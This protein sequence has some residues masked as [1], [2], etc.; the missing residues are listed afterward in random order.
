M[1]NPA[2]TASGRAERAWPR[3]GIGRIGAGHGRQRREGVVDG[4]REHRYAIERAAGRHEAGGG[5]Q[6]EA[7]LEAD[8]VAQSGRHAAR[9]GSIGAERERN[10]AGADRDRRTRARSA[11][12][13]RGIEQVA[14][15]AVGRAHADQAGG[16]LIEIGLA[17]DDGAGPPEPRDAGR[18]LARVVREGRA[19]GG[20]RQS[21]DVDIVLDRD[22]H[23]VE[24]EIGIALGRQRRG[25]GERVGFIAQR[26]ENG[27][28]AV[29]ADARVGARDRRF[30]AARARTMR[31][32]DRGY[33]LAHL[34]HP[35]PTAI[36]T[37]S[38]AAT[39]T[40]AHAISASSM[41]AGPAQRGRRSGQA[42]RREICTK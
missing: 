21:R 20:G 3:I 17:D 30:G 33:R 38:L 13:E 37:L 39:L 40:P 12:N 36:V 7:R 16:E 4:E 8:D 6:A 27:G 22:R 41:P 10:E 26:D 11:G 28:I 1:R 24:R 42:R 19:G 31:L 29:G 15:R 34:H 5:D 18:V 35:L 23:A 25:F 9:P 2:G 32:H 14:R